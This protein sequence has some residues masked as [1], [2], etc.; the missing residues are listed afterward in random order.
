MVDGNILKRYF[1]S[2]DF[3]KT[4]LMKQ[5]SFNWKICKILNEEIEKKR[6]SAACTPLALDMVKEA[7][8]HSDLIFNKS[9]KSLKSLVWDEKELNCLWQSNL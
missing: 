6:F 4:V 9:P 2:Q 3:T 1:G 8:Q 7:I 5:L